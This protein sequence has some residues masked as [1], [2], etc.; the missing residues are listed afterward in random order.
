M[1]ASS[2]TSPKI[3]TSPAVNS[4][5]RAST[6]VVTRVTSR[7]MGFLSKYATESCWKRPKTSRR[8]SYMMSCP[9]ICIRY[10][11]R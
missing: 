8:R 7:P 3:D 6:S 10:D 4:S 11:W 9:I 5:F 1:P 2:T